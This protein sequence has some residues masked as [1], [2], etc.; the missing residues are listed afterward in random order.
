MDPQVNDG[1]FR[2]VI[3]TG[4]RICRPQ[5]LIENSEFGSLGLFTSME[6]NY[7]A[8]LMEIGSMAVDNINDRHFEEPSEMGNIGAA[9]GGGFKNTNKLRPMK[10]KEAMRSKDKNGKMPSKKNMKGS[11]NIMF[12]N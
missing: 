3:R 10:Y 11:R 8:A 7:Y 12:L 4:R 9:L 5:R 2:T 1:D 6:E